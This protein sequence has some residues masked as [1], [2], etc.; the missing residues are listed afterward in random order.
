MRMVRN[1]AKVCVVDS[2][3]FVDTCIVVIKS[4]LLKNESMLEDMDGHSLEQER[5]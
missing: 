4:Y 2:G 1:G 3:R 5:H